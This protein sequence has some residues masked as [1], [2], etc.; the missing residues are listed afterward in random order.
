MQIGFPVCA[1]EIKSFSYCCCAQPMLLAPK[2]IKLLLQLLENLSRIKI[3]EIFSQ[4]RNFAW[5]SDCH[6]CLQPASSQ[7]VQQ[8]LLQ[9]SSLTKDSQKSAPLV[10]ACRHLAYP[11]CRSEDREQRCC[12]RLP[13]LRRKNRQLSPYL[14]VLLPSTTSLSPSST[15]RPLPLGLLALFSQRKSNSLACFYQ[16]ISL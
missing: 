8:I 15:F 6:C 12:H 2:G 5:P 14:C 1:R 9:T 16:S 7:P 13:L 10:A 3:N 11:P 4:F